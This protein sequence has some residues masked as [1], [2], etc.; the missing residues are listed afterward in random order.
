M[1]LSFLIEFGE[2]W[3]ALDQSEQ[4]HFLN[5]AWAFKDFLF[6]LPVHSAYAQREGLLHLIHIDEFEAIVS[7]EHKQLIAK[8]YAASV[9]SPMDDIDRQ[10]QLRDRLDAQGLVWCITKYGPRDEWSAQ[11]QEAFE[12]WRV[13]ET[14]E[15][16]ST[17]DQLAGSLYFEPNFLERVI[18][19]LSHKKQVIF[20]GPPGTGKTFVRS[21]A[22]RAPRR[23]RGVGP[24][25]AVPP[26]VQLRGLRPG[27]Q[28]H[29][30][31][32]RVLAAGRSVAPR[33]A[34]RGRRPAGD[35]CA[36]HRRD[37][38]RDL[39]KV[40]GELYFLLEYRKEEISLQYAD[41]P[42]RMPDN[43]DASR[44]WSNGISASAA[45]DRLECGRLHR[46]R[47]H[48]VGGAGSSCSDSRRPQP[49]AKSLR[50]R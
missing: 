28:A 46:P 19:L 26:L 44:R 18:K 48:R 42:F 37:Q 25:G 43:D 32:G 24:P 4:T 13:G 30:G 34:A 35:S 40:L 49:T 45:A 50:T 27:L 31:R 10:L 3:K 15:D 23:H 29:E 6:A 47:S 21:Q 20:H 36:D 17:L 9:T 5:D 14:P 8:R 22:R 39:A 33:R 38:S 41:Q 16:E 1:R 2:A 7:R 11:D 12:R